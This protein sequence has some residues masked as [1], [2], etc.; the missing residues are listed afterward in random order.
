MLELLF[1]MIIYTI[2]VFIW[3]YIF[4]RRKQKDWTTNTFLFFLGVLLFWMILSISDFY[5]AKPGIYVVMKKIQWIVMLNFAPIFLGFIYA[6]INKKR[7]LIFYLLISLNTAMIIMRW[8]LEMDYLKDNFWR[9]NSIGLASIMATVFSLPMIWAIIHVIKTYKTTKEIK[10]KRALELLL[11]GIT[12]ATL[13]SVFSEYIGPVFIPNLATHSFMYIAIL[14]LILFLFLAVVRERFL[15]VEMEYIYEALFINSSDGIILIDEEQKIVSINQVVEDIFK[16][17]Q[18]KKGSLVNDIIKDYD[19]YKDNVRYEISIEA[20]NGPAYL[21]LAQNPID[22]DNKAT[23][24]LL[25]I[26]DMTAQKIKEINEKSLLNDQSMKDELTGLYN[27]RYF[28]QQYLGEDQALNKN[29]IVMFID[30]DDFKNINDQH[31]HLMGDAIIK[32]VGES[33]Q[34]SIRSDEIPIRY[35]GD[36]FLIILEEVSEASAYKIAKRINEDFKGKVAEYDGM[37]EGLS[38]SIGLSKGKTDMKSLVQEADLAMYHSKSCGK[39]QCTIYNNGLGN[40][41]RC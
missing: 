6:L 5:E 33:I 9:I 34:G 20:S 18:L 30:I 27:R 13:M 2:L 29:T 23:M 36:E 14:I 21:S 10:Q 39:D 1:F 16:L 37:I 38:L 31:G 8:F 4:A 17:D 24:K 12:L 11:Y 7:D 28:N 26:I 3:S 22:I 19:F 35:G 41:F 15:N 25:H 32:I 40:N